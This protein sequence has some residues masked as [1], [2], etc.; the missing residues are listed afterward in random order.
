MS[1]D[2]KTCI[3]ESFSSVKQLIT[4]AGLIGRIV[5]TGGYAGPMVRVYD[6]WNVSNFMTGIP[7][8]W[9]G[10]RTVWG[11]SV[12]V[13]DDPTTNDDSY[14][15]FTPVCGY[16]SLMYGLARGSTVYATRNQRAAVFSTAWARSKHSSSFGGP[17]ATRHRYVSDT[18]WTR[19][20]EPFYSL[21]PYQPT[22]VNRPQEQTL[23]ERAVVRSVEGYSDVYVSA[24]DDAQLGLFVA[25]WPLLVPRSMKYLVQPAYT[26]YNPYLLPKSVVDPEPGE[27]VDPDEPAATGVDADPG[28]HQPLV[29]VL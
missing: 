21:Y 7:D 8:P 11:S 16:L 23:A 18:Y 3:G 25:T 27:G 20:R 19:A 6:F 15:A 9:A 28:V 13:K 2:L 5:L 12:V 1:E 29:D 26:A 17:I 22:G 24:A 10:S 4:R 14:K